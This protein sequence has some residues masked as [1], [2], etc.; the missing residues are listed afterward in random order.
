MGCSRK[1]NMGLEGG[2]NHPNPPPPPPEFSVFFS[3]LETQQGS[4]ITP[5]GDFKA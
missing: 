3:L 2:L 5:L 4:V 1:K